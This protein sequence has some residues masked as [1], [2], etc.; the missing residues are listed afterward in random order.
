VE[1]SEFGAA[2]RRWRGRVSPEAAGLPVGVRRRTAGL[3]RE[4]LAR[5]AGISVDYVTRLEQGRATAPSVQVVEAIA[6]SLRLSAEER[7]HLYALSGLSAPARGG[8]P[9][10]VPASIQRM[11]D[12]L[13]DVP[14][15]VYDAAWNLIVANAPHAALMGDSSSQRG[16]ERNGVWR[17]F[18]GRDT[19]AVYTPEEHRALQAG[20]VADLRVA[21]ANYPADRGLRSLIAELR[22][23]SELFAGLWDSGAVSPHREAHKLIDHPLV[24]RFAV[25][26][27]ILTV[28]GVDLRIMVYTAQPGTKD[29]ELLALATVLG[30]QSLV[31]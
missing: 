14:V 31:D 1:G 15:A 8:V 6:R 11:L 19:R 23:S 4:E 9:T 22:A 25:D 7:S 26:C 29:S 2:V 27:D 18:V 28:A 5:L 30:T 3:R 12:R 10:D 17:N 20:L 13:A 21:A 24:G 16:L